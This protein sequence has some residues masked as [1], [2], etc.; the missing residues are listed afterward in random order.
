VSIRPNSNALDR[1]TVDFLFA[2]LRRRIETGEEP[3]LALE[4][5]AALQRHEKATR[6]LF[7][8]LRYIGFAPPG[9]DLNPGRED[10]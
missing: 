4:D 2:R 7:K 1:H 8:S 5:L 9:H 3:Q 10:N 6:G